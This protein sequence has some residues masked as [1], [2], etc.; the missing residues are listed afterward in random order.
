MVFIVIIV[1]IIL[2][3]V[4]GC[5][6]IFASDAR[7]MQQA[8]LKE[9]MTEYAQYN[10][11]THTLTLKKRSS[12]LLELFKIVATYDTKVNHVP[13][14]L[15]YGSVTVGG[16]TSGG[17]YTTGGYNEVYKTKNGFFQLQYAGN[18]VEIIKL[19]D[20][21]YKQAQGSVV[22]PYLNNRQK[23][24]SLYEAAE[25]SPQQWQ[26]IKDCISLGIKPPIMTPEKRGLPTRDKCEKIM[27]WVCHDPNSLL[28]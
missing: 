27:Y 21:L 4:F 23:C 16:V 13:E 17:T 2:Y 25:Y 11:T 24:I 1:S 10:E 7:N 20:D 18:L 22:E 28:H 19:S 26:T 5:I 8:K 6:Y 14:R 3:F 15:H 12:G 9:H